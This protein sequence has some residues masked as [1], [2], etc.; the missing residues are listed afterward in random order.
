MRPGCTPNSAGGEVPLKGAM[1]VR[2]IHKYS[3]VFVGDTFALARRDE[4]KG[5]EIYRAA[6]YRQLPRVTLGARESTTL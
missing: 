1:C 4:E 3:Y 2:A 5:C 6:L